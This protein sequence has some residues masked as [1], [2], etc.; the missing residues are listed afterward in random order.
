VRRFDNKLEHFGDAT[1]LDRVPACRS[2][3]CRETQAFHAGAEVPVQKLLTV[4]GALRRFW[5]DPGVDE[6]SMLRD[7][8]RAGKRVTLYPNLDAVD[9]AVDGTIG[10]DLKAYLSPEALGSRLRRQLSGLSR[11]ERKLVVIPDRLVAR[12]DRYLERLRAALGP[13]ARDIECLSVRQALAA[14][15]ASPHA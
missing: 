11:Y 4:V 3:P 5:C 10:I 14:L 9:L 6:L 2:L 8:E 7:L 15:G 12:V 13:E 1:R